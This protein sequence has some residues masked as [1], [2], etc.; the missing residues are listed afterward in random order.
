MIRKYVR[1]Y[2]LEA[3]PNFNFFCADPKLL[4]LNVLQSQ[5]AYSRARLRLVLVH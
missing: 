1:P 5:E 2:V 3:N 4:S